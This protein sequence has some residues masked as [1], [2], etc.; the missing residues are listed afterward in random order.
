MLNTRSMLLNSTMSLQSYLLTA[1]SNHQS[2][3]TG[4]LF[5]RR[6]FRLKCVKMLLWKLLKKLLHYLPKITLHSLGG[7]TFKK[8]K[9]NHLYL[10]TILSLRGLIR[11]AYFL[12]SKRG[13]NFFFQLWKHYSRRWVDGGGKKVKSAILW[14]VAA[15]EK[16]KH[17]GTLLSRWLLFPRDK[18]H[19]MAVIK[20]TSYLGWH[21]YF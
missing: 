2:Y 3:L 8:P 18:I 17:N 10:I 15:Q 20:S 7:P 11:I 16:M 1:W 12:Q 4:F 9:K 19:A 21:S 5:Q 14:P 6:Q 13:I